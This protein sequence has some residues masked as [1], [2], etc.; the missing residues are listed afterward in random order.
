[1]F[2]TF[3]ALA[4]ACSSGSKDDSHGG[5]G[6]YEDGPY[7]CCDSGEG[8]SCCPDGPVDVTMCAGFGGGIY[9]TC[10]GAGEE[11]EGKVECTRCCEG[12]DQTQPM[13]E[14]DKTFPDYPA[15][16][17]PGPEP[18]S[19]VLCVACGDGVCGAGEN[20]CVCPEDCPK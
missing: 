11:F 7:H 17:G 20:R 6:G 14:T 13:V 4:I 16:C 19:I 5:E 8:N 3:F 1:M 10:I 2:V 12:L 18:P 9:D 15:G